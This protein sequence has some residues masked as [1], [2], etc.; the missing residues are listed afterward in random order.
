M[1]AGARA[2]ASEFLS[3]KVLGLPIWMW[4]LIA[5]AGIAAYYY[6]PKVLGGLSMA[7][8]PLTGSSEP[9]TETTGGNS[10]DPNLVPGLGS[11]VPAGPGAY[12][13]SSING[14]TGQVPANCVASGQGGVCLPGFTQMQLTDQTVL[15]CPSTAAVASVT[16]VPV[17]V[18]APCPPD[19]HPCHHRV[20]GC[21]C[22][23]PHLRNLGTHCAK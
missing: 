1:K 18:K 13:P 8:P 20:S 12:S 7:M 23:K 9:P 15:C 6:L 16:N 11:Y 19:M 2:G 14:Y 4:G 3:T 21:C 17:P 10:V 22:N 5:G